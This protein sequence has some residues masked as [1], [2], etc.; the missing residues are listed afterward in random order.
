MSTEP[1]P[2]V[3]GQLAPDFTLPATDRESI[4]LSS[5]RDRSCLILVFLRGFF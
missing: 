5:Y 2:V 1:L 3:V 4:T